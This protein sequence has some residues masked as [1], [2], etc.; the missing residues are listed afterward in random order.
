ERPVPLDELPAWGLPYRAPASVKGYWPRLALEILAAGAGPLLI[1][2]PQRANAEKIARKLSK[3]LPA[4]DRLPLTQQQ[5]QSCGKELAAMLE[6][7]VAY[8]H[9]GLSYFQRAGIVEPLAKAGQLRVV[10]AT[11]GLA[12]GINFSMRSV[13][14]SDTRFFNGEIQHDVASDELLQ[15]FGR[16]G[17]R[18]LDEIGY[19]IID[20]RTPR[21]AD[22]AAKQLR[23]S[24]EIDW[25][26]LLRVM[27]SAGERGESAIEAARVL[28]RSLFSKQKIEL[29]F[30]KEREGTGRTNESSEAVF[31]LVP[32]RREVWNASK[33]WE[34]WR[35]DRTTSAH[36]G[37]AVIVTKKGPVPALSVFSF[38]ADRFSIGRM[39]KLAATSECGVCYGREVAAA[40]RQDCG[41]YTL[42]RNVRAWLKRGKR[43]RFTFSQLEESIVPQALAHCEGGVVNR[44][45]DRNGTAILTLDFTK[46][47]CTVYR[48]QTD[49]LLVDPRERHLSQV[50][51]ANVIEPSGDVHEASP[52]SAAYAWR[53][54]GLIGPDGVP[55]R[56]GVIFSFFHHGDGLAVAAALEDEAYSIREL[57]LHLANIRG[58]YRF[59]DVQNVESLGSERLGAACRQVYGAVSH[60]GYL[61]L[62]L[63]AG[64]GE[65]AAEVLAVVL[66]DSHLAKQL[67]NEALGEGDIERALVEWFSFLRHIQHAPDYPWQRWQDL[68]NE[69]TAALARHGVRA[70]RQALPDLPASLF[71]R[72]VKHQIH[73]RS[74]GRDRA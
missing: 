16:A 63:P 39:A 14:V 72:P 2:A 55:T 54:L 51:E 38:V 57:I 42:T 45:E 6:K 60:T 18:G 25:P 33:Q 65:G 20:D 31:G 73:L 56:R 10:V 29:G 34:T 28:C 44:F 43:D 27:H 15:M 47:E 32:T 11:M 66:R 70:S 67:C 37:A 68:K 8:H 62:G 9:S 1:F 36:L 17:R 50:A 48:D 13:L 26:T 7:R 23:R 71:N 46:V 69:A 52:G 19:V 30:S 35:S 3:A 59:A 58:G 22:A 41:D 61:D 21:L 64:Y 12:A 5:K 74:L 53:K 4:D 40:V 49:A 24:N